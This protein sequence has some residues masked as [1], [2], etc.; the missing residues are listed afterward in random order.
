RRNPARRGTARRDTA[1]RDTARRDAVSRQRGR[2]RHHVLPRGSPTIVEW[3]KRT[4]PHEAKIHRPSA[5]AQETRLGRLILTRIGEKRPCYD[6]DHWRRRSEGSVAPPL[7]RSW[8]SGHVPPPG[9]LAAPPGP[10]GMQ[11][12]ALT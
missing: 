12:L 6:G 11:R 7:H 9:R 1:R 5:K 3:T 4:A 10:L 2:R 8:R